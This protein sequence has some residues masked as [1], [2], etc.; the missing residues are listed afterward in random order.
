MARRKRF[1]AVKVL[2]RRISP[3]I[4]QLAVHA[5]SCLPRPVARFCGRQLG[6]LWW[7]LS[8]GS[9]RAAR[10]NAAVAFP[11]GSPTPRELGL[12]ACRHFG[13]VSLDT[14]VLQRWG[15]EKIKSR[16]QLHRADE[17]IAS[18]K[19]LLERGRGAI[20]IAPH[21]GNWELVGYLGS[22][23]LE[24][25]ACIA[26]RY[27]NEGYQRIVA[28]V[29]GRLQTRVHYQD[30]GL[31][32]IMKTLRQNGVIGVLPDLDARRM[33]GLFVPFF[34]KDA[35]TTDTPAR[36]SLKVGSPLLPVACLARDRDYSFLLG[37][38][39][40]PEAVADAE[41]PVEELTR[42]WLSRVEE[43][44][45]EEPR[46]WVWMHRRWRSTPESVARRRERE[47]SRERARAS[48]GSPASS[49]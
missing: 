44:I 11:Q 46:Q 26:K 29:R 35:Y 39:I 16:L 41:N 43:L 33:S 17:V 6:T 24:T 25:S 2:S 12:G 9:R 48:G 49:G 37:E 40:W 32:P 22:N 3:A 21:L 19:E 15:V 4:A 10:E 45:R 34:G 1:R 30:G 42:I 23:F 5:A 14:V 27:D 7:L 38:P 20:W 47:A 36:L 31:R 18:T 28:G 13:Q 8:S